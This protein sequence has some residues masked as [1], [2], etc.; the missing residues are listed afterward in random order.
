MQFFYDHALE[1]LMTTAG[2][3]GYNDKN[4]GIC[5]FMDEF[6][7]IGKLEMLASAMPYLG[8]FDEREFKVR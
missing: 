1:R 7:S 8:S 3:L 5:L 6:Y 2:E 4:G